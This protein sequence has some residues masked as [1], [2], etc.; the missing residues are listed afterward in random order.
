MLNIGS[1]IVTAQQE[2]SKDLRILNQVP[3][4]LADAMAEL[5]ETIGDINPVELV[6]PINAQEEQELWLALAATR[7]LIEPQFEYDLDALAR[8]MGRDTELWEVYR[9]LLDVKNS[10]VCDEDTLV[11]RLAM[12]RAEDA[13]RTL[14][15]ATAIF[16]Q[17]DMD[18]KRVVLKKY[19]RPDQDLVTYAWDQ[20]ET[21]RERKPMNRAPSKISENDSRMLCRRKFT[22]EEIQF[23]FQR[24]LEIYGLPYWQVVVDK[25]AR[26]IDVRD[27]ALHGPAIVIPEDRE[28]N[29][30]KLL[31]LIGHEIECHVRDSA[32]GVALLNRL[33]GGRLKTDNEVLYEGHAKVMDSEFS[34]DYTSRL[35]TTPSP[36]YVLAMK[37]A[38]DGN[39][40]STVAD[41]LQNLILSTGE[42][43]EKA[44][45]TT[46]TTTYR[47][48]RGCTHCE[49]QYGYAFTKDKAYLEGYI[50]AMQLEHA[51]LGHW[52]EI[53]I[54]SPEELIRV[55]GVVKF[56]G[57]ELPHPYMDAVSAI[58]HELLEDAS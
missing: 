56:S 30:L 7:R 19:G 48:F 10:L 53:G 28:V 5:E 11:W 35:V 52:L 50:Y 51:K 3:K 37:W 26:A 58:A 6:T 24:A 14:D 33:G 8:V 38:L 44:L 40:F 12:N 32:N 15:L 43:P 36:Y 34:R 55:A 57:K 25:H 1:Q 45:R 31:E 39:S 29:G 54:L 23:W 22:A 47:V 20:V 13:L 42:D 9:R 17:D 16:T 21:L 2:A 49:N 4:K 18:A 41:K 27:K 46:W